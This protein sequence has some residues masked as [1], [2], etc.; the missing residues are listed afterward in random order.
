[1]YT[2]SIK[3]HNFEDKIH[4]VDQNLQVQIVETIRTVYRQQFRLTDNKG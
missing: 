2:I 1:M 4:N 3:V